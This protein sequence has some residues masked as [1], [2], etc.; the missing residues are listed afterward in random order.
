MLGFAEPDCNAGSDKQSVIERQSLCGR[1]SVRSI[2]P[3]WGEPLRGGQPLRRGQ[4]VSKPLCGRLRLGWHIPA[5]A[6]GRSPVDRA[7]S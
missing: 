3:E 2:E 6:R 7:E 1:E 4:S 5:N